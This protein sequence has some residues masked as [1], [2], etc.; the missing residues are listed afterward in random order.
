LKS[1][2]RDVDFIGTQ[3]K[4][5]DGLQWPAGFDPDHEGYYG[6]TTEQ[7]RARLVVNLPK[8]PPPDIAL[9][10][11]GTNDSRGTAEAMREIV[12]M[13]RQRNPRVAVLIA[14]PA[15]GGW[16]GWW[17]ARSLRG[18]AE[19]MTTGQ[20]AVTFV[21]APEGWDSADTFDGAHPNERGQVRQAA[22]WLGMLVKVG[23]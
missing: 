17:L 12:V 7:V 22:Q 14:D 15:K 19:D 11:L 13:L 20:S 16:R 4:G 21:A 5:L 2:G 9:I 1:L 6:Q 3:T 10:H 23:S 8:L 18:L